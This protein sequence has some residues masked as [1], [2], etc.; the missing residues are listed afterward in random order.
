MYCTL[1]GLNDQDIKQVQSLEDELGQRLLAFSCND[2]QPASLANETLSRI[3]DLEE[4]LG[5]VL[6][7]VQNSD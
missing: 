4:K 6:L 2:A 1:S 3:K 5:V 7:A